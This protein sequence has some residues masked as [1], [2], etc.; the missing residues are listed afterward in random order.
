MR[1]L[2]IAKQYVPGVVACDITST[3]LEGVGAHRQV[4]HRL[5][6]VLSETVIEWNPGQGFLLRLERAGGGAPKPLRAAQFRYHLD[7][8]PAPGCTR[9]ST[10]LRYDTG[11]G[12]MGRA[13]GALLRPV[14][15]RQ[16]RSVAEELK[17]LCERDAGP[18]PVADAAR[19]DESGESGESG[20]S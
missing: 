3:N 20:A 6:P 13:F 1:D 15:Q 5:G 16:V 14:I 12:L 2:R 7:D 4:R 8:A 19:R 11:A 10:T 9:L 17:K 18:E